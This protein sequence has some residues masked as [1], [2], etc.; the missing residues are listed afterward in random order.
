[1]DKYRKKAE[2]IMRLGDELIAEK[3]RRK[4]AIIRRTAAVGLG[5]AAVLC[6]GIFS[7]VLRPPK[8]P[9]TDDHGMIADTTAGTA[10]SVEASNSEN[11]E[12]NA[13]VQTTVTTK[14]GGSETSASTASATYQ[15][16]VISQTNAE[17][18]GRLTS[19]AQE[20]ASTSRP[21]TTTRNATTSASPANPPSV[22]RTTWTEIEKQTDGKVA[23]GL[24]GPFDQDK[25]VDETDLVFSGTVLGWKEYK[26]EWTDE[27]GEKWGPY[28]SSVIEVRINEV[29]VGSCDNDTIKVYYGMYPSQQSNGNF[30]VTEGAELIF[31]A[32]AFDDDYFDA[33]S[34]NPNDRFEQYKYADVYI[35]GLRYNV[36]S[37]ND[38]VVLAYSGYFSDNAAAASK[39]LDKAEVIG[40]IPEKLRGMNWYRCFTKSDFVAELRKLF[41]NR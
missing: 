11:S 26:V 34:R 6:I 29:Y 20:A 39:A 16:S 14:A 21:A 13:T 2:E 3:K 1:M 33:L 36:M 12:T 31:M 4:A 38:D 9:L 5:A 28:P 22:S 40:K 10:A 18:T 19:S 35:G 8:Q 25:I 37:V 41:S 27:Q 15:T 30:P 23:S 17:G 32:N 24:Y 7:Q